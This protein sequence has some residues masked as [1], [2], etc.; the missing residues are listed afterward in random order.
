MCERDI[1][2]GS[3]KFGVNINRLLKIVPGL[4]ICIA[5]KASKLL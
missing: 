4:D 1:G 3:G 2:I 5:G